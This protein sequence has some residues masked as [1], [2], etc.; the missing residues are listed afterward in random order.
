MQQVSSQRNSWLLS[1]KW[2]H[3]LKLK[4][5][6]Q[7]HIKN[8]WQNNSE[9]K[10]ENCKRAQQI[11]QSSWE[12]IYEVETK[13]NRIIQLD[14]KLI[15]ESMKKEEDNSKIIVK[16]EKCINVIDNKVKQAGLS[17]ATLEISSRISYRF[18]L[19]SLSPVPYF[20]F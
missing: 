19:G 12:L 1:E 15:G 6:Y 9:F 17:R 10:K 16:V 18:S 14:P 3:I 7:K 13:Y 11:C 2:F 8:V 4:I 20:M 5:Q